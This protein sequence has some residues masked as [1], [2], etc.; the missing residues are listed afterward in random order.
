MRK[1]T[2]EI[3]EQLGNQHKVTQAEAKKAAREQ[4]GFNL[5]G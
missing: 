5:S 3:V 2:T 4:V 1:L